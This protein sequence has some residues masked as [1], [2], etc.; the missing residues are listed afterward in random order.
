M[1]T[2]QSKYI[3][4]DGELVEY[5][6]ATVHVLTP[7]LHYGLSAFEG[8]R[9]YRTAHG[10][11]VFRL[12]EHLARLI[13]SIS[14]LGVR[15]FPYSVEELRQ[16]VHQTIQANELQQCYIRPLVYMA[17][18]PLGINLD[19]SKPAVAI[20]VF[21]WGTLLGEEALVKGVRAM[22]SSFTRLHPNVAMTK[23][24]IGGNYVNSVMAKTLALR[25]GFEE[26]IML[27]PSGFVAECTG[28]NL[29]L[30]RSGV[31]YT[32]PRAT[33]LEGITRD[34]VIAL[35]SDKGYA[36][37]EEPISR[38]QLYVADEVFVSGTAAEVCAISEIDTRTIG[39]GRMGAVTREIQQA[40]FQTV[41][42]E[43]DRSAE[44]LD[45]VNPVRLPIASPAQAETAV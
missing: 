2:M 15:D 41:R 45:Y 36:L 4:M 9:C 27:D 43:G 44:W 38:D 8:I 6:K 10:P 23:A 33:V 29:F 30:V 18:G 14:I 35:A 1:P 20:A 34:A 12:R 3:W 21:E 16:A 22:V 28:E 5:A 25:S 11:A 17:H 31:I 32:P 13:D 40:F 39:S 7:A 42:G 37:L 24:K 26:A 19:N